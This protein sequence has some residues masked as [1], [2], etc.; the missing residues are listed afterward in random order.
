MSCRLIHS[1]IQYLPFSAH[2]SSLAVCHFTIHSTVFWDVM[3][4]SWLVILS[5]VLEVAVSSE[6]SENFYHTKQYYI[7]DEGRFC[8]HC[9][10]NLKSCTILSAVSNI[11]NVINCTGRSVIYV[12]RWILFSHK[13]PSV[14]NT[15]WELPST[16]TFLHNFC[17][18]VGHL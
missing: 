18:N 4:C 2:C 6:L 1:M 7:P 13:Q 14:C 5:S 15:P 11:Q 16:Y 9:C 3:P 10:E 17:H 8:R 12:W